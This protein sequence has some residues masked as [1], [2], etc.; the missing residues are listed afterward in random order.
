MTMVLWKN[1]DPENYSTK[2]KDNIMDKK[3]EIV[4]KSPNWTT[5]LNSSDELLS[6]AFESL[7]FKAKCACEIKSIQKQLNK[8]IDQIEKCLKDGKFDDCPK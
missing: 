1:K 3:A 8:K 6:D 4:K 2:K 5:D 7:E